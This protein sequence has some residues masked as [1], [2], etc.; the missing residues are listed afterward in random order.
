[1]GFAVYLWSVSNRTAKCID[2]TIQLLSWVMMMINRNRMKA[3]EWKNIITGVSQ[4]PIHKYPVLVDWTLPLRHRAEICLYRWSHSLQK[5]DTP[6]FSFKALVVSYFIVVSAI[7]GQHCQSSKS[8]PK[9]KT[10]QLYIFLQYKKKKTGHTHGLN[11]LCFNQCV[12]TVCCNAKCINWLILTWTNVEQTLNTMH[13]W[14]TLLSFSFNSLPL[15][16]SRMMKKTTRI[17]AWS[18]G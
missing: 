17:E 1:M 7:W 16:M 6:G 10:S 2:S 13:C 9:R 15:Q 8:K 5:T 3:T 18:K 4:Y 14:Y 11:Q 12:C